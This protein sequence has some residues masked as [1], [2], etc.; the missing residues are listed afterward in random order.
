MAD[1]V[2]VMYAGRAVEYG[3]QQGD[4]DAPGDALHLGSALERPRRRG[5]HRRQLIPIPGN[6][7]SLLNPPTGCAFHPRCAHRDK[8]PGDLCTHRAARAAARPAR[9]EP[10]QALPPGRTL[11]PSTEQRSCR[12]RRGPGR[13]AMRDAAQPSDE[14]AP[15]ERRAPARSDGE[16]SE[17]HADVANPTDAKPI[18][19]VDDLKMYFPVKSAGLDPAHGRPRPGRRRRLLPGA[20]GRLAG[21]GRRVG[22]RQVHDRSPDHPALRAHRRVDPLR[23]PG[24]HQDLGRAS[25]SRCA[26]RSR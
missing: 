11:T 20:R 21:P 4:P 2:L 18:L 3:A 15:T 24:H 25:S 17:P 7:P 19:E 26:A 14:P 23:R 1:D 16:S 13:G 22:L 5:R 6:P 12:D 8:V 9:G 10:P